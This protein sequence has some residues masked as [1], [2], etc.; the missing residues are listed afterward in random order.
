MG[1]TAC[2]WDRFTFL[3]VYDFRTASVVLWSE[4]LA[5]NPEVLGSIHGATKCSA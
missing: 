4:F 2:C 5:D 1:L 3:Y